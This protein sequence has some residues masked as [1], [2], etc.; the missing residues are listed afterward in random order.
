MRDLWDQQ[1]K[2]GCCDS[3]KS[4][5]IYKKQKSALDSLRSQVN[6]AKSKLMYFS[7]FNRA[8]GF[9]GIVGGSRVSPQINL[10]DAN[11]WLTVLYGAGCVK[12]SAA[13]LE[14]KKKETE[15]FADEAEDY[16]EICASCSMLEK[17]KNQICGV[18]A[19]AQG[20]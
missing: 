20:N 15:A 6:R 7:A 18:A 17:W 2:E 3:E 1:L 11:A 9:A 12:L 13:L 4:E 19:G 14:C 5:K 16:Y 10:A 8:L